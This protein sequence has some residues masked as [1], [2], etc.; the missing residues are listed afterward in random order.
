MLDMGFEAQV[1]SI[2]A[3]LRPDRQ[4]LLFSA[5]MRPSMRALAREVL[6]ARPYAVLRVRPVAARAGS[7]ADAL[8]DGN[9]DDDDESGADD[10]A[11]DDDDDDNDDDAIGEQGDDLVASIPASAV[12]QVVHVLDSDANKWSWLEARLGVLLSSGA[13][14]IVFV[15]TRDG[16]VALAASIRSYASSGDTLVACLHGQMSQDERSTCMR[17]LQA[18]SSGP[19]VLVATDVAARGLD[20]P[21]ITHVL[22]YDPPRREGRDGRGSIDTH[23]HRIGRTGRQQAGTAVTQLV[24]GEA[25]V[26]LTR[27]ESWFA[28][29]LVHSLRNSGQVPSQ[30]LLALA[31]DD[32]QFRAREARLRSGQASSS[33]SSSMAPMS[34][35][36]AVRAKRGRDDRFVGRPAVRFHA[37]EDAALPQNSTSGWSETA[38]HAEPLPSAAAPPASVMVPRPP[39]M[40]DEAYAQ[41]QA[42]LARVRSIAAGGG[43]GGGVGLARS[44]ALYQPGVRY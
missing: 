9:H 23:V 18:R 2:L 5:T 33:S 1:R 44:G 10:A 8:E 3:A 40:S 41:L 30:D 31:R 24:S 34:S 13:R 43:G 37:A 22:C 25:H 16:A 11:A 35:M 20:L 32:R 39:G 26:V 7:A 4:V 28:A 14:M 42:A 21:G 29:L 36:V 15:G 17:A 6:G 27:R 12:R 38:P 19:L